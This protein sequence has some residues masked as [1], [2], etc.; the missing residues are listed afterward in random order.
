MF[1]TTQVKAQ[2]TQFHLLLPRELLAALAWNNASLVQAVEGHHA[3]QWVRVIAGEPLDVLVSAGA[4]G[5]EW[6][7][8]CRRDVITRNEV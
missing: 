3:D 1:D 4:D 6:G 7:P 8:V 2:R 5:E